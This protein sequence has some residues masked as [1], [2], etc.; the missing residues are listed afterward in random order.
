M[1]CGIRDFVNCLL[2]FV[3]WNQN[4][5]IFLARI[6]MHRWSSRIPEASS[7][8]SQWDWIHC[9]RLLQALLLCP[10]WLHSRYPPSS[11]SMTHSW[12]LM[13]ELCLLLSLHLAL[14]DFQ[15]LQTRVSSSCLVWGVSVFP[16]V[17][18]SEIQPRFFSVFVSM[19]LNLM[20]DLWTQ[21]STL[22]RSEKL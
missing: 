5:W 17:M 3:N 6:L 7:S 21:K 22:W 2:N 14:L 13:L 8:S 16:M 20:S 12:Q 15:Q 11:C 9:S 18:I 10:W 4:C 1:F 19:Q